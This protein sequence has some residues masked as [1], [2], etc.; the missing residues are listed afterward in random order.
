MSDSEGSLSDSLDFTEDDTIRYRPIQNLDRVL[1]LE[2]LPE[3]FDS[4][5]SNRLNTLECTVKWDN[6]SYS[7]PVNPGII[8]G[9]LSR[10]K[11]APIPSKQVLNG[12]S[13]YALPGKFLAIM[14]A[15]GSGKTTLLN[16]LSHRAV[17]GTID[18]EYT[19]NGDS[20]P[21]NSGRYRKLVG[22]VLQHDVLL[23]FLTV[24]ETL[25]FAAMLTLPQSTPFA[26]KMA[27]VNGLLEELGLQKCADSIV[28][29][30]LVCKQISE[31]P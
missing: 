18:G 19:V 14:G 23:P 1:G 13:G 29:N 7:V 4:I 11:L 25:F 10:F 17:L 22:Y 6:I 8:K 26:K 5:A 9:F 2:L 24:R 15:S 20:I 28:G 30:Q 27:R 31:T 16:I 3:E 12:I 21:N